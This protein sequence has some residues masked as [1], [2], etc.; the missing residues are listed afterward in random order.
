MIP[1][2]GPGY[3]HEP[4]TRFSVYSIAGPETLSARRSEAKKNVSSIGG[5]EKDSLKKNNSKASNGEKTRQRPRNDTPKT[6]P[7]HVPSPLV[8]TA[9]SKPIGTNLSVS[10]SEDGE[11]LDA[12]RAAVTKTGAT[13]RQMK[14]VMVCIIQSPL[15]EY[16]YT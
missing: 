15:Q 3:V 16:V 14:K 4:T 7:A 6:S 5:K 12:M 13:V 1:A 2:L 10:L 11:D 8:G 9:D